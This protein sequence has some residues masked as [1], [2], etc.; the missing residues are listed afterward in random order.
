MFCLLCVY[1]FP[2][3]RWAEDQLSGVG[4]SKFNVFGRHRWKAQQ[5]PR[6]PRPHTSC[7]NLA[8]PAAFACRFGVARIPQS[9]KC[10]RST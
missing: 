10:S 4:V 5:K 6:L 9:G 7:R 8:A 3:K 2:I 1:F